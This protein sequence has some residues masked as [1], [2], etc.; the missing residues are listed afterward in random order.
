[1]NYLSIN[2]ANFVRALRSLSMSET[3]ARSFHEA[4]VRYCCYDRRKRRN[5]SDVGGALA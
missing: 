4:L 3:Q 5:Y 2:P 1:M